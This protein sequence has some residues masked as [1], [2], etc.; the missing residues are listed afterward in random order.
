MTHPD[1]AKTPG[2]P[3]DE[4]RDGDKSFLSRWSRRKVAARA[5]EPLPEPAAVPAP[6]AAPA[7]STAAPAELPPVESL[8]G[9]ESDYRAFLRPDVDG[10]VQ[11]A[12]LKRLFADPHFNRMD[13]LDVYID[14]YSLPDPIPEAM[15]KTL[16]HAKALFQSP[17]RDA[18]AMPAKSAPL[19]REAEEPVPQVAAVPTES[20]PGAERA[21]EDQRGDIRA[22]DSSAPDDSKESDPRSDR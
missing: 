17:Q 18:D 6:S 5:G 8:K 11:R 2:S 13:G 21:R 1:D 15:M 3:T 19:P 10:G 9:L 22:P 4:A 7:E 20:L 16:E 12:A 14:D